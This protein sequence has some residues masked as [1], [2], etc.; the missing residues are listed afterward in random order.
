MQ[1]R[2]SKVRASHADDSAPCLSSAEAS[3]WRFGAE[4]QAD[5]IALGGFSRRSLS[6]TPVK[7][8]RSD[9]QRLDSILGLAGKRCGQEIRAAGLAAMQRSG[10]KGPRNRRHV[11]LLQPRS[12][13][14]HRVPKLVRGGEDGAVSSEARLK[15]R[16]A[17][18]GWL[19]IRASAASVHRLRCRL[20][21]LRDLCDA[22]PARTDC[23]AGA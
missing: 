21:R 22:G 19:G 8:L 7:A 16:P 14:R 12:F 2:A 20:G 9:L 4:R 15:R 13:P 6:S 17:V 23:R 18:P 11:R 10:Y 1:G 3:C 5:L